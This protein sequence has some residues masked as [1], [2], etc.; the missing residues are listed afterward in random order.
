[1]HGVAGWVL[2]GAA[3]NCTNNGATVICT[4][5]NAIGN[6]NTNYFFLVR[7]FNSDGAAA[8]SNR[9]GEFDFALAPGS[10]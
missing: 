7:V 2:P 10:Q 1:L 5:A 3:G 9:V 8:D 4:H 6:P